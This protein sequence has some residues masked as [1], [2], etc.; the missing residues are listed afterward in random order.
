MQRDSGLAGAGAAGDDER[1]VVGRAH[2]LVL[3][4][5]DGRDDV[6]HVPAALAGQRRHERAVADDHRALE[7]VG[8]VGVEKL[9]VDADHLRPPGAD[10]APPHDALGVGRG[11]AVE[12]RSGRRAPVDDDRLLAVGA[13]PQPADVVHRP[14]VQVEPA[15]HQPL[16]GGVQVDP[17]GGGRQRR[18]VALVDRLR[19]TGRRAQALALAPLGLAAQLGEPGG[20]PVQHLLLPGQLPPERVGVAARRR[21]DVGD[22]RC[23]VPVHRDSLPAR[24]RGRCTTVR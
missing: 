9:V 24:A 15:E 13:Q 3:L 18:D 12:G 11:R 2:R 4:A 16:A 8:G 14:L 23:G 21:C 17:A 20:G 7:G 6:A 5:L 10:G 22:R 1:A 19:R